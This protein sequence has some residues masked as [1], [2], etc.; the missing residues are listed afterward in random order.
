MDGNWMTTN[1]LT[2]IILLDEN[3]SAQANYFKFNLRSPN[4]QGMVYNSFSG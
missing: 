3:S 1:L 2:K 4:P